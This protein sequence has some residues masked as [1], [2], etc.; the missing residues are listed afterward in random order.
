[1][2]LRFNLFI[3]SFTICIKDL[4]GTYN[5]V[6][7]EV[8]V[9]LKVQA[10]AHGTSAAVTLMDWYD[11]DDEVILVMERP[12]PCLD[13]IDYVRSRS[14]IQEHEVKVRS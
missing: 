3:F 8:A 12:V 14:R 7:M 9:M 10:T 4:N 13:L 5:M 11:L 6:P 1:M 2:K